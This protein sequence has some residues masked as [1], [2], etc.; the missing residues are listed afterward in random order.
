MVAEGVALVLEGGGR[1]V[2]A[3]VEGEAGVVVVEDVRRKPRLRRSDQ[4]DVRRRLPRVV[5][6]IL[7]HLGQ[8]SPRSH[9]AL[10]S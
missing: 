8:A 5:S 9:S 3:G 4:L 10:P 2:E 1:G 7:S 6:S